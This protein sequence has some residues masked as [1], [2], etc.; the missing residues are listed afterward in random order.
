LANIE[1]MKGW[2][3]QLSP[4]IALTWE[5]QVLSARAEP[6]CVWGGVQELG[7]QALRIL[8]IHGMEVHRKRP[9]GFKWAP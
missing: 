3:A 9:R 4:R 8:H 1:W 7:R 5:K 2:N 6:H